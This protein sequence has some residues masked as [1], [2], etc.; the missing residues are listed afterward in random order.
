[1]PA[2]NDENARQLLPPGDEATSS[3]AEGSL[4]Y[5]SVVIP[6]FNRAVLI[7]GAVESVLAQTFPQL[8]IIVVDDGSTDETT[9]VVA[10]LAASDRRV[11][12]VR[13]PTH[14][15]AQAARNAGI[16]AARGEWVAFLDSDDRY[17]P[18][19]VA[20]RLE[21]A[22]LTNSP[23]VHSEALRLRVSG[24]FVRYGLVDLSGDV[25]ERILTTPGVLFPALMVRRQLLVS[26][27]YLDEAIVAWQ[28]WDTAIRLGRVAPFAY[29][30][31]P[32]FVYDE[33]TAGAISKDKVR[34]AVGYGQILTK[35]G[36]EI[37]TVCGKRTL[38][39]HAKELGRL[40]LAAGNLPSAV[41]SYVRAVALWPSQ[42]FRWPIALA[43]RGILGLRRR[44]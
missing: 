26:I 34:A 10:S 44:R 24:E 32:T 23:V 27:G 20:I 40:E 30:A 16:R 15:G 42:L 1:M 18:E 4:P 12:L 38:A 6:T 28:E 25:Y 21:L 9:E 19:S 36:P 11:V 35:F 22:K 7:A 39:M 37:L 5:V 43:R 29:S 13:N 41:V 3:E 14:G 33:R 2:P 31:L 8:E 17:L